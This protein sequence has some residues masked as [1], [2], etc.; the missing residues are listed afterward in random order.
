M[1]KFLA[2]LAALTFSAT[3]ALAQGVAPKAAEDTSGS[4][5]SSNAPAPRAKPAKMTKKHTVHA[6]KANK[7]KTHKVAH[8]TK[9]KKTHK[10]HKAH[11]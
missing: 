10:T 4:V 8:K 1:K 3:A 11:H 7:K 6:K 2:A 5:L 9:H